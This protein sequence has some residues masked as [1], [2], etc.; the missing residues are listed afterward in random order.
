[1]RGG[2]TQSSQEKNVRT[3]DLELNFLDLR[4]SVAR[5]HHAATVVLNSLILLCL[6]ALAF[7]STRLRTIYGRFCRHCLPYDPPPGFRVFLRE[8]ASAIVQRTRESDRLK[9]HQEAE[10]GRA[11]KLLKRARE[12]ESGQ[13]K[14][15]LETLPEGAERE[16]IQQCLQ[17]DNL[18]DMRTLLSEFEGR[19]D[20]RSPDER[21]RALLETLREYCTPEEFDGCCAQAFEILER[22]GFREARGYAVAAH[23]RFRARFKLKEQEEPEKADGSA[24]VGEETP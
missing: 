9:Q 2:M 13:L 4:A 7:S 15:I 6:G 14:A 24:T 17:A 18:E 22:D 8:E 21:L 23:D 3:M 16:R 12:A 11:A 20:E 10:H 5:R 19:T 1:L